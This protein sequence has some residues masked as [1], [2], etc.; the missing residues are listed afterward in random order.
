MRALAADR[1]ILAMPLPAI[2]ADLHE[3]LDVHG[4]VF[5]QVAF[6]RALGLDDLADA[7]DLVFVEVLDFLDRLNL[8]GLDDLR[9]A[10]MADAVDVGKRDVNVFVARK[11][12]ACNACHVISLSL[13]LLVLGVLADHPHRSPA[14]DDLAFIA[15]LLYRCSDLHNSVSS[16]ES[17]VSRTSKLAPIYICTQ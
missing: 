7:V 9:G 2:R 17:R 11:I 4:D 15:N 6:D 1:Q 16:F 14:M 8:G 12:H 10:R 5:A 13:T 3:P